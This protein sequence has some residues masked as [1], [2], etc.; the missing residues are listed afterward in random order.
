VE[1]DLPAQPYA[2]MGYAFTVLALAGLAVLIARRPSRRFGIG[3]AL[4]A[5]ALI[6]LHAAYAFQAFRN[7]L[8]VAA[9]ACVTA[10][11]AVA[12]AGERLGRPRLAALIGAAF[13]L[14]LFGPAARDY[15]LDRSRLVDSRRQ[16]VDW[17][18]ANSQAGDFV[19]ILDEAAVADSE[20][21]RVPGRARVAPWEDAR[22]AL[23]LRKP[24]LVLVPDLVRRDGR[25]LI[26]EADR[27]WL[28]DRYAV[29]AVVGSEGRTIR[30][31]RGNNL[32]LFVLE[33][34]PN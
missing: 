22:R 9:L 10:G 34:T 4:F 26:P 31:W 14:L 17:L 30:H 8:P 29:R 27:G 3:C 15:A 23:W 32:R 18:A 19:L 1:W 7:L 16:A 13:L 21:A 12:A 6:C 33:R 20:I 11:V 24:R 2:E 5:A 28:L 25:H